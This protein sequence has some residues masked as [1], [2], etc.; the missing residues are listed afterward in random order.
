LKN[1]QGE[2]HNLSAKNMN[3][4]KKMAKHNDKTPGR[5]RRKVCKKQATCE[6][7]RNF[8]VQPKLS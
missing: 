2:I 4:L 5:K 7:E 3:E 1:D 6:S 8:A